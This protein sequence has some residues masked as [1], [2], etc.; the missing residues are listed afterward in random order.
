M[1][2][3]VIVAL[4]VVFCLWVFT[5]YSYADPGEET[6]TDKTEVVVTNPDY[7]PPP[8]GWVGEWPPP[9]PDML[10]GSGGPPPNGSETDDGSW[11]DPNE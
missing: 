3:F 4:A 7:P 6:S 1:K 10:S 5:A 9:N 8:D 2:K 11:G